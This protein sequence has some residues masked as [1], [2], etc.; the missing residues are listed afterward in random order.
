MGKPT[1]VR[2]KYRMKLVLIEERVEAGLVTRHELPKE[3]SISGM[4]PMS[5]GGLT[6]EHINRDGDAE[7]NIYPPGAWKNLRIIG[8]PPA[9]ALHN[10]RKEDK[11]AIKAGMLAAKKK[12]DEE[13]A[14]KNRGTSAP[15]PH[16]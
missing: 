12:S 13:A 8:D 10:R 6:V 11:E 9:P 16:S 7:T 4:T 2:N 3:Y 14:A 1:D 5:T 15:Q